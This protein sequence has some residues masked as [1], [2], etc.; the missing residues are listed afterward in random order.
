MQGTSSE[1]VERFGR[2]RRDTPSR[3]LVHLPLTGDDADGSATLAAGRA[4]ARGPGGCGRR[5]RQSR[6]EATGNRPSCS[7]FWLGLPMPGVV[8]HAGGRRHDDDEWSGAGASASARRMRCCRRFARR[9]ASSAPWSRSARPAGSLPRRVNPSPP[10]VAVP[11]CSSSHPDRP[12]CPRPRSRPS[13]SSSPTPSTSSTAMDIRPDDCQMAAIPLSHA[14]G[15]G[16]LLLPAADAGHRRRAARGVRPARVRRRRATVRRAGVPR[17]ARSCSTTSSDALPPG[18]GRGGCAT[19]I[20]A[21]AR[22][23]MTT[24]RR[25]PRPRSA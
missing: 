9:R 6:D 25:V 3:P 23:E 12:A 4:A 14:Y 21:G 18:R 15:L 7:A 16:N 10:S 24:A 22:L 17:R 13:G 8:M 20:S 1:I 5:S 2:I 11:R 19:L